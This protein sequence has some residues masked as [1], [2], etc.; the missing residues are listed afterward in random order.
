MAGFN[1]SAI[2][3][4]MSSIAANGVGR[5]VIYVIDKAGLYSGRGGFSYDYVTNSGDVM[6][7]V[8][9]YGDAVSV[10]YLI[11]RA[12]RANSVRI[13]R[14]SGNNLVFIATVAAPQ[15]WSEDTP[16]LPQLGSSLRISPE[17]TRVT[18]A[19][20]RNGAIWFSQTVFLPA[21]QPT[22]SAV[23]W[24]K[25]STT[26]ELLDFGRIDD[27]TG[28][29]SYCFPSIAVNAKNDVVI[30]FSRFSANTYPSAG[31]AVR[32]GLDPRGT[33]R[34][35]V[36]T[37]AGEGPYDDGRWGD[38]SA[39]VPDPDDTTFWTLQE[40][41]AFPSGGSRW[42]VWWAHVPAPQAPIVG[43]RRAARH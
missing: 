8:T 40:Y 16:L 6:T 43:K 28:A 24:W 19:V 18:N 5:N 37:K 36:I 3:I 15:E 9:V 23:Q 41:A 26:G 29:V 1:P 11:E 38:Y 39:T 14:E 17:D 35:P 25:V 27:P 22:R 7:P 32:S 10:P 4:A 20:L 30:G 21:T 42:G 13:Y 33:F 2:T 31:Y 12:W 34:T